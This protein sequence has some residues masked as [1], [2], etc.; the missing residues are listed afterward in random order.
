MSIFRRGT[1]GKTRGWHPPV[2]PRYP[3]APDA[4]ALLTLFRDCGDFRAMDL[5]LGGK[6]GCIP[7][8]PS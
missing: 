3:G 5:R 7:D 1:K 4:G 6:E 8:S 2:K